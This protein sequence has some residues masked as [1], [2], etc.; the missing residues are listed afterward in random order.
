MAILQI[1]G[2]LQMSLLVHA[3]LIDES[4]KWV[5]QEPEFHY[6]DLA[7][8]ENCR[9]KLY[10]SELAKRLGLKLLPQ[11]AEGNLFVSGEEVDQ[12]QVEAEILISEVSAFE[13]HTGFAADYVQA[14]VSNIRQACIRARKVQGKV[15]IW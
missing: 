4:G 14:S 13:D 8:F 6:Q 7:G 15:V 11:L 1:D 2:W 5:F 10:G 12:L 3:Y 9:W